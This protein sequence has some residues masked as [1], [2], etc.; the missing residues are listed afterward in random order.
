MKSLL[1][2]LSFKARLLLLV[3]IPLVSFVF[4]NV[5]TIKNDWQLKQDYA[6]LEHLAAFT[7][8]AADLMHSVQTERGKSLRLLSK[9]TRGLVSDLADKRK[10]T[11]VQIAQF[12]TFV[13]SLDLSR[14]RPEFRQMLNKLTEELE[15]VRNFRGQVSSQS[16]TRQTIIRFYSSIITDLIKVIEHQATLSHDGALNNLILALAQFSQLTDN[17][18]L[19]RAVLMSVLTA[20]HFPD[21]LLT[22]FIRLQA[23][24]EV[25]ATTFLAL[26]PSEIKSAYLAAMEAPAV[27]SADALRQRVLEQRSRTDFDIAPQVWR[28]AQTQKIEDLKQIEQALTARLLDGAQQAYR[29][30]NEGI[31]SHL[32]WGI[33]VLAVTLSMSWLLIQRISRESEL[34]VSELQKISRGQLD[35]AEYPYDSPAFRALNTMQNNLIGSTQDMKNVTANL[36]ASAREIS[37]ANNALSVRAEAQGSH[38][39]KT[40]SSMEEITTTVTKNADNAVHGQDLS[41][42]AKRHALNGRQIVANAVEAMEHI[43]DDSQKIRDIIGV[44]DGIAFQTNLLALNAAV[45]AA[46]AGDQGKGFSV[47]ASE[48]RTLAQRS[49]EAAREIKTLI[50]ASVEKITVGSQLAHDSGESL[51]KIVHAVNEV[52]ELIAQISQASSEQ[53]SGIAQ[54]NQSMMELDE[55]NQQNAA[56]VEEVAV[57]SRLLEDQAVQLDA[58]SS[59]YHI[60]E[61]A[62]RAIGTSLRERR[63]SNRPWAQSDTPAW[64]PEDIATPQEVAAA[65]GRW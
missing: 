6:R 40:A 37:E 63:G 44:I 19:E 39:E 60:G 46:R 48:V 15:K 43:N 61:Q 8:I 28:K 34:M 33:F 45:E 18:R 17:T 58:L 26:A 23:V 25:T 55:M 20:G 14:Y 35:H 27:R 50:E 16:T 42:N 54:V 41:G 29:A 65:E 53:A 36:H 31:W 24:E 7:G 1:Q 32:I 10:Q 62:P 2:S 21:D 3:V 12:N 56:M 52:N 49:A 59:R 38:L 30:A 64:S 22:Q 9:N 13:E 57:S 5:V 51:E 11:D 47:V 4:S